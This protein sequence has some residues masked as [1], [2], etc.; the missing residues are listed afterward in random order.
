MRTKYNNLGDISQFAPGARSFTLQGI[1]PPAL[2]SAVRVA[3]GV[4]ADGA[5]VGYLAVDALNQGLYEIGTGTFT[6]STKVLTR[7]PDFGGLVNFQGNVNIYIVALAEDFVNAYGNFANLSTSSYQ[8]TIS[9]SQ[10]LSSSVIAISL[11]TSGDPY[12]I[13]IAS[14]SISNGSFVV[15]CAALPSSGDQVSYIVT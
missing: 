5:S 12:A 9:D 15:N 8:T 3:S 6:L 13:N 1:A 14:G 7:S 4:I 11:V 10:I 2:I